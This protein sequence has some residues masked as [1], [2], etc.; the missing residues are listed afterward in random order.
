M[1]AV[2]NQLFYSGDIGTVFNQLIYSRYIGAM[3]NQ[4]NYSNSGDT[5]TMMFK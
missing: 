4:P 5:G 3:F 2:F 1:G